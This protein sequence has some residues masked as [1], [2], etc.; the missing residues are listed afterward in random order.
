MPHDLPSD[1]ET[2]GSTLWREF[3]E[4]SYP[5]PFEHGPRA[6]VFP[7]SAFTSVDLPLPFDTLHI[8]ARGYGFTG[9]LEVQDDRQPG[10]DT[11]SASFRV[12]YTHRHLLGLVRVENEHPSVGVHGLWAQVCLT[13]DDSEPLLTS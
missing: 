10:S 7:F 13:R 9:V 5:H 11:V 2:V 1:G 8:V 6:R 12:Y 3:S 4:G